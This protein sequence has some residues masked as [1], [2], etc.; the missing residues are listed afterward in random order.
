M[1]ASLYWII[2]FLLML[3]ALLLFGVGLRMLR[4]RHWLLGWLRGCVGL[5]LLAAAVALGL[6]GWD[7]HRFQALTAEEPVATLAFTRLQPQQ[8]RVS[9]VDAGGV[10]QRFM[11]HG[12]LWQLDVRMIKWHPRLAQFGVSPGYQLE[13]ISG[14]Y[15]ALE[16]EQN[17]ARTVHGLAAESVGMDVWRLLQRWDGLAGLVDASYGSA[18]YLPM[19]DGAL[20]AVSIGPSGLIARPRNERAR[21]VVDAW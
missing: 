20:F 7:L 21:E 11:L 12:D 10:E 4:G 8:Y 9:V 14:R 15:L 1:D 5:G 16:Q 2:T 3:A 18:T 17:A 19:A 6:A 13:R